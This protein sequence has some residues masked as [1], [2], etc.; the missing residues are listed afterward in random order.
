MPLALASAAGSTAFLV[1]LQGKTHPNRGLRGWQTYSRWLPARRGGKVR[2][3]P[4]WDEEA[5]SKE[6]QEGAAKVGRCDRGG[7]VRVSLGEDAYVTTSPTLLEP[8]PNHCA[9]LLA[10]LLAGARNRSRRPAT[11]L[12]P[13]ASRIH[14]R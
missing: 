12:R 14:W 5:S 1:R 13:L 8:A 3:G 6:G 7:R 4:R 9:N 11:S 2:P 10:S